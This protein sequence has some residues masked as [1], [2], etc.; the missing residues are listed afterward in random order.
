MD[1]RLIPVS[2]GS[3][4]RQYALWI[5]SASEVWTVH[6]VSSSDQLFDPLGP[7]DVCGGAHST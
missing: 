1:E 2:P 7:G 5:L 3:V 4:W 6:S